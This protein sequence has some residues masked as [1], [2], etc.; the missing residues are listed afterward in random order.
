MA[1][2]LRLETL[3]TRV[4][5]LPWASRRHS[6]H[7]IAR[8][9]KPQ[10]LCF[11][12]LTFATRQELELEAR[13]GVLCLAAAPMISVSCLTRDLDTTKIIPIFGPVSKGRPKPRSRQVPGVG[14][15]RWSSGA[16]PGPPATARRGQP[17]GSD[18]LAPPIKKAQASLSGNTYPNGPWALA[19]LDA[20]MCCAYRRRRRPGPAL[21][22]R[23]RS[24]VYG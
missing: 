6:G 10:G 15:E 8:S 7:V 17:A 14:V 22:P 20:L 13:D 4:R 3:Q 2:D 23:A 21:S 24:R 19:Q 9:I 16:L 1:S 18:R 5:T 11:P 12:I